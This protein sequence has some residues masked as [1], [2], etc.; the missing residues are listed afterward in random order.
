MPCDVTFLLLLEKVVSLSKAYFC[1]RNWH[2]STMS[3]KVCSIKKPL[4][5]KSKKFPVSENDKDFHFHFK[6]GNLLAVAASLGLRQRLTFSPCLKSEAAQWRAEMMHF[7]RKYICNFYHVHFTLIPDTRQS[8]SPD[9]AQRAEKLSKMRA[10]IYIL[11]IS[12]VDTFV[13]YRVEPRHS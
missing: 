8:Y 4:I 1:P 9:N 5:L 12:I 2:E 6:I 7:W 3:I 11:L 13:A 10:Q